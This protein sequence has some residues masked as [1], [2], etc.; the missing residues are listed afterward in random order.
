MKLFDRMRKYKPTEYS[1]FHTPGHIGRAPSLSPFAPVLQY[2]VSEVMD[3]D[4]IYHAKGTLKELEKRVAALFGAKKSLLSA[5]GCTLA[6]QTMLALAC[7]PDTKLVAGRNAHTSFINTCALLDL[8]PN[9]IYPENNRIMTKDVEKA[10][11]QGAEVVY[12]TSP[13]YFGRIADIERIAGLCHRYGAVLLVDNAH[14]S[15]LK[16]MKKDLHPITLGAD[17]SACSLHKTLPVLT[18]GAVLNINNAKFVKNAKEK[19]A[20]FG[21]TSPSYLT[22]ASIEM[23]IDYLETKPNFGESRAEK[24]KHYAKKIGLD[25]PSG[26]CDPMRLAVYGRNVELFEK[27]GAI[28]EYADGEWIVFI[29]TPFHDDKDIRRIKAGL[30]ALQKQKESRAM[31]PVAMSPPKR[32]MR[33]SAA[34][35]APSVEVGVENAAGRIAAANVTLCPPGIPIVIPGEIIDKNAIELMKK[36]GIDKIKVV[37]I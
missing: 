1:R 12:I 32:G 26:E 3:F 22:L 24:I 17:M 14:G 34:V 25:M 21:S 9:W 37:K 2:D 18:G 31:P 10:L 36:Q 8:N 33:P 11:K 35:F 23:C 13:D 19:M 28:C 5:G 16:F 20:L 27:N 4:S 29:L 6:I 7:K 15:H 30:D